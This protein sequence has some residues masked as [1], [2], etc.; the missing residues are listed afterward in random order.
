MKPIKPLCK[1]FLLI[2]FL[3]GVWSK[4]NAQV[5]T[6][7]LEADFHAQNIYEFL[8]EMRVKKIL[9]DY[10]DDIL[11]L[12]RAEI[13]KHLKKIESHWS[14]LSDTEKK[15]T[16]RFQRTFENPEDHAG[17][18]TYFFGTLQASPNHVRE[19]FSD[20]EKLLFYA[21]DD[22]NRLFIETFGELDFTKKET[23]SVPSLHKV[24][25]GFAE[26]SLNGLATT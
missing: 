26:R 6:V 17:D 10:R 7:P 2:S 18:Y 19:M 12:P 1:Q 8:K 24:D 3:V 4:A 5:E 20:K 22:D 14:D 23:E 13:I 15:L 11:T 21:N 16:K 25:F 9:L